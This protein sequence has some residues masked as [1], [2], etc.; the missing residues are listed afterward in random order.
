MTDTCR[1]CGAP[2]L[3][4]LTATGRPMPI[5]RDA[6][7]VDGNVVLGTDDSGRPTARIV[8]AGEGTH[9]SHFATCPKADEHRRR[10]R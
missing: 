6:V 8:A 2:I 1:S 3:F 5:D 7:L 9:R 4:A 10:R